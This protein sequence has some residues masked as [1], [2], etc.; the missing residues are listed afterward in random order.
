MP[1]HVSYPCGCGGR[2]VKHCP[3]RACVWMR[4]LEC[5][6]NKRKDSLSRWSK[7]MGLSR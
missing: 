3:K 4:C 6:L 1:A 7:G 2:M 5:G